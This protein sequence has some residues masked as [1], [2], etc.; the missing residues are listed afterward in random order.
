MAA[1]HSRSILLQGQSVFICAGRTHKLLFRS[2]GTVRLVGLSRMN[3]CPVPAG[4]YSPPAAAELAADLAELI[5]LHSE[6]PAL[7]AQPS[8]EPLPEAA[9]QLA[10]PLP[11]LLPFVSMHADAQQQVRTPRHGGNLP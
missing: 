11:S 2:L 5:V 7:M 10:V 8:V 4:P 1:Q 9:L 6:F 3:S